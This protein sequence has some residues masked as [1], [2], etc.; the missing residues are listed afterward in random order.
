M[1][2]GDPLPSWISFT[3]ASRTFTGTPPSIGKLYFT[4]I[5]TLT[6]DVVSGFTEVNTAVSTFVI[7]G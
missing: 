3:P 7:N 6:F 1:A 4:M 5:A 2:N